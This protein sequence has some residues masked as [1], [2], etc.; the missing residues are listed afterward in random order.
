M[1]A[2]HGEHDKPAVVA[3]ELRSE[4]SPDGAINVRDACEQRAP[5]K[6]AI[7]VTH[8]DD[9]STSLSAIHNAWKRWTC[10]RSRYG[11]TPFTGPALAFGVEAH[12]DLPPMES[13]RHPLLQSDLPAPAPMRF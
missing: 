8:G 6:F 4:L 10:D 12:V 11:T 13:T 2:P 3:L 9:S 1:N 7:I 5:G